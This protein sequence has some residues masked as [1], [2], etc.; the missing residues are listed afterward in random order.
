MSEETFSPLPFPAVGGLPVR[1]DTVAEEYAFL[2]A[3]P[4]S[5]G[6]W[7]IGRQALFLGPQ[8][9][10]DHLQVTA[11]DGTETMVR[12]NV[13]SFHGSERRGFGS[14]SARL[15]GVMKRAMDWAKENEPAHP[16]IRPRFPVAAEGY[17]G[18]VAVPMALIASDESKRAG[19]YGP[20]RVV[21]LGWDDESIVGA[22]DAPGFDPLNWPPPRLSTWPPPGLDGIERE[23]LSGIVARFSAIWARLLD[24]YLSGAEYPQRQF[25]AREA[26]QLLG[27]LDP[28]PMTTIYHE[29]SPRFWMWLT[30]PE[31]DESAATA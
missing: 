20:T 18:K 17:P 27:L 8:G 24:A 13:S 29:V 31:S 1:T 4:H 2:H 25:E 6:G 23:R 10:E 19:I 28:P 11:P 16:G 21:V 3:Y 15:D 7:Q 14:P 9:A 12:F 22:T 30:S 26:V 5:S